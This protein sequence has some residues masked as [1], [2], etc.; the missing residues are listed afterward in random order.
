MG[1]IRLE[2]SQQRE[3]VSKKSDQKKMLIKNI[4]KLKKQKLNSKK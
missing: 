4:K 1:G 3:N 2:M